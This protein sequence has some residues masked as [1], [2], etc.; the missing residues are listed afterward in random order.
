MDKQCVRCGSEG[1][2][3]KLDGS[4]LCPACWSSATGED[5]GKLLAAWE[6]LAAEGRSPYRITTSEISDRVE[7]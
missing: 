4:V 3:G 6:A 5:E 1:P 7:F 2:L